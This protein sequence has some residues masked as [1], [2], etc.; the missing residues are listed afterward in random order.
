MLHPSPT[1]S[2]EPYFTP[3]CRKA[4][5]HPSLISISEFGSSLNFTEGTLLHKHEPA[6]FVPRER[7]PYSFIGTSADYQALP[8][9][10][11]PQ[12][13]LLYFIVFAQLYFLNFTLKILST[14]VSLLEQKS[15][16]VYTYR[17]T[18]INVD[19]HLFSN[20]C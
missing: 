19:K 11:A 1:V 14:I 3:F 13:Y 18:H 10:S 20:I 12:R 7:Q 8:F 15:A 5:T 2:H 4:T 17:A 16:S 6:G 9:A